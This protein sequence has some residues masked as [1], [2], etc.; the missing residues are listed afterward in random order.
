MGFRLQG[1]A[2][3]KAEAIAAVQKTLGK[4]TLATNELDEQQLPAEEMLRAY[5][6]QGV[7]PEGGIRFLKDPWCFA[8]SLF[9]KNPQRIMALVMV[10]VMGLALLVYALAERKVRLALQ[11]KG[12]S[13]PNQVGK[14]TQAPTMRRIFQMFE[15]IDVLLIPA[16]GGVQQ[17]FSTFSLSIAKSF[18]S[19]ALT[20]KNAIRTPVR[21]G[22]WAE[23]VCSRSRRSL[24]RSALDA[25]PRAFGS[26]NPSS[27]S[28]RFLRIGPAKLACR[29][30]YAQTSL[31]H[32]P[33]CDP[34]LAKR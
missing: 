33:C 16:E 6:G 19:S 1:K 3:E 13:I 23:V 29:L 22:M 34:C 5:K 20:W 11:E 14:P 7:G 26:S 8:D 21:C 28:I 30:A 4:F 17:R 25:I 2:V 12:E 31:G 9:L 27:I 15:G 32:I 10:M 24:K 18:A